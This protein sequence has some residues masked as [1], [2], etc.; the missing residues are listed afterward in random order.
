MDNIKSERRHWENEMNFLKLSPLLKAIK[1][2]NKTEEYQLYKRYIPSWN[3]NKTFF[4]IWAA[5]G[6]NWIIFNKYFWYTPWG[7]EYTDN[8]FKSIMRLY[9]F[10]KIKKNNLIKWDIF[11]L[12]NKKTYDLVF[13]QWFIE[14]FENYINVIK[15]HLELTK[16]WWFVII[17]VPN[18]HFFFRKF[19]DF[20]YPSLMCEQHNLWIMNIKKF[21]KI[22]MKI[23]EE[24]TIKIRFIWWFGVASFWQLVSKNKF[25][26]KIIYWVDLICNKSNLYKYFWK[27]YS[28]IIMIGEKL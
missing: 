22:F 3:I 14:H 6:R 12:D 28:S 4:E 21:E 16:K 7:I 11:E 1:N 17:S 19:Q 10:F 24:K 5:P 8:W 25:I 18:Y 9:D 27:E 13:S 15:K 2:F 23:E 26:Q 20:L